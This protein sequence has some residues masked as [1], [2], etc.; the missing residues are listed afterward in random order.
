MIRDD[1]LKR[2]L[3]SIMR[4]LHD[5]ICPSCGHR[6]TNFAGVGFHCNVC[7][8]HLTEEEDWEIRQ[9]VGNVAV[10]GKS[11]TAFKEWQALRAAQKSTQGKSS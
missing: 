8:L 5:G 2:H 6:V 1:D 3:H 10:L 9:I 7:D 11:V 4:C